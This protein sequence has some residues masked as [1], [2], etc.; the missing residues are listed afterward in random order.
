M[1]NAA[2]EIISRKHATY[3]GIAMSVKRLC[4]AI[5]RDEKHILPVSSLMV[6]EYGLSD[7]AISMPTIVGR[8]GIECRV[9]ISLSAEELAELHRSASALKDVI[10]QCDFD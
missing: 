3:Y 6:G 8:N 7:I 1:K 5:M 4:T 10:D 2:Y 9:P